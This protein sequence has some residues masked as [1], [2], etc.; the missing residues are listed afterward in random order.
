MWS[1]WQA[2]VASV[3][4]ERAA[5]AEWA[6]LLAAGAPVLA[7]LER[8]YPA[9]FTAAL[10]SLPG[11]ARPASALRAALRGRHAVSTVDCA[12]VVELSHPDESTRRQA[13]RRLLALLRAGTVTGEVARG[14]LAAALAGR[15]ERLVRQALRVPIQRWLELVGAEPL[16]ELLADGLDGGASDEV[17]WLC[18]RGLAELFG[19]QRRRAAGTAPPA[20]LLTALLPTAWTEA[21]AHHLAALLPHILPPEAAAALAEA[22]AVSH[23]EYTA[24]ALRARVS[25]PARCAAAA[26][27]STVLRS[28]SHGAVQVVRLIRSLLDRQQVEGEAGAAAPPVTSEVQLISDSEWPWRGAD[29]HGA[30]LTELF[31]AAAGGLS[32]RPP[33]CTAVVA[34]IFRL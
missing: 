29:E 5:E 24:A 19:L 8:Q 15:S 13:A 33:L 18:A 2:C 7:A 34:A 1:E 21:T 16:T 20:A 22:A 30:P 10:A 28:H 25:L 3:V 27:A 14:A 17:G 26:L 32:Q 11:G 12:L 9:P 23:W 4:T 31:A 6:P